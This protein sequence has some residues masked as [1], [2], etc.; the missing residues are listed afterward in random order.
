MEMIVFRYCITFVIIFVMIYNSQFRPNPNQS[1]DQKVYM[2][3]YC[4]N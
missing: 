2:L 1:Y 3:F 4:Y